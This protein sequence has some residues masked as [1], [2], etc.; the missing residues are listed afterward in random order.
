MDGVQTQ[1]ILTAAAAAGGGWEEKR[2]EKSA[3][4][5]VDF[6]KRREKLQ[7]IFLCL[8]LKPLRSVTTKHR[9]VYKTGDCSAALSQRRQSRTACSFL[10][11]DRINPLREIIQRFLLIGYWLQRILLKRKTNSVQ[12]LHTPSLVPLEDRFVVEGH[13]CRN[14]PSF[15]MV[16]ISGVWLDIHFYFVCLR[17]NTVNTVRYQ[18]VKSTTDIHYI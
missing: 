2:T 11:C 1:S 13:V 12:V 16:Q 6:D 17:Y 7:T 10:L 8:E 14:N 3:Y 9:S 5:S 18:R 4:G 15:E